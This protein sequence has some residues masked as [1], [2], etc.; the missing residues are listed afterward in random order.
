MGGGGGGVRWVGRVRDVNEVFLKSKKKWGG[1]GKSAW[2]GSG[3]M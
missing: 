1:G 3:W 2:G